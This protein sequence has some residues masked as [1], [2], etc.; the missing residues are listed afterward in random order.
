MKILH[1]IASKVWG[2]A[3]KSFTELCNNLS[4]KME[5]IVVLPYK[6]MIEDRLHKNIKIYYVSNGS[7]YQPLIYMQLLTIVKSNNPDIVHTHSAKASE[8]VYRLNKWVNFVHIATKRNVRK[9]KVFNKIKYVTAISK[10]TKNSIINDNVALV[11]N[12]VIK[13]NIKKSPK[14]H[15]DFSILAVGGL[16]NI[17]GFD[18]L[19]NEVS[20]LNIPFRL[21]IA[22]DGIEKEYLQSLINRFN[23]SDRVK[24]IGYQEDIP[25][26][27]SSSDVVVI[28]SHSEGFSRVVV[29]TLF[30]GKLLISTKVGLSV[31]VLPDELLVEQNNIE[32]KL[33]QIYKNKR[34]YYLLFDEIKQ[35]YA[36]SFELKNNINQY[37]EFYNKVLKNYGDVIVTKILSLGDCNMLGDTKFK[38]NSYVERFSKIIDKSCKNLGYTMSTTR[39]MKYFFEDNYEK[40]DV[41]IIM[42]QYGLVDSW[43]TF[44]YAPYVLY[45]PD[46]KVRKVYRK[47]V[48]KYKKIAK[49][50]K[51]NDI[52]GSQNVVPLHEYK[53][54]IEMLIKKAEDKVI[55][56]IDT[57]PHHQLERN[58][59][60]VKYNTVLNELSHIY[61]N[62]YKLDIYNIFLEHL[63]DYYLDKTHTNDKGY[64]VITDKLEKLYLSI[65]EK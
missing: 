57:I 49:A 21:D 10:A 24:L 55:I 23:L 44:K 20:K 13:Y 47:I 2:G 6:N 27:I 14:Q 29:E 16:D 65:K 33:M 63:N 28:S 25:S 37:I 1:Y 8:I 36:D 53:E 56:L 15:H 62:C 11:Y 19:I 31:E 34:F 5:I 54:N 61:P 58:S 45:Y 18:I 40:E 12:G 30:Y 22:G 7:R 17:K 26:L 60:I 3:E 51:L 35:K 38:D 52:L 50:L 42:I 43:K 48:K 4:Q 39:E 59:E 64:K 32:D 41:E 9:G 46:N